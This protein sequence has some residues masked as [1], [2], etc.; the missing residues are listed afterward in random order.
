MD[1]PQYTN[2]IISDA[3][4]MKPGRYAMDDFGNLSSG[5]FSSHADCFDSIIEPEYGPLQNHP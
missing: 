2:E 5:P 3:R 4:C 1:T